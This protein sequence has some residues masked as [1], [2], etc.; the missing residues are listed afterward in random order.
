MIFPSWM[1]WQ[2]QDPVSPASE[3]NSCTKNNRGY[4]VNFY[5]H[6]EIGRDSFRFKSASLL[7]NGLYGTNWGSPVSLTH[8]CTLRSNFRHR[9][10]ACQSSAKP[11]ATSVYDTFWQPAG[12]CLSF[13]RLCNDLGSWRVGICHLSSSPSA[14]RRWTHADLC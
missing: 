1:N 10:G 5:T 4:F 6:S 7:F 2:F 3:A 14:A 8:R 11:Q 9:G 12:R 13:L